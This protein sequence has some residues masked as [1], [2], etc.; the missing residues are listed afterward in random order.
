MSEFDKSKFYVVFDA[1]YVKDGVKPGMIPVGYGACHDLILCTLM[2]FEGDTNV[3]WTTINGETGGE[4]T[5]D[6]LFLLWEA[7]AESLLEKFEDGDTRKILCRY[8]YEVS[9]FGHLAPM[10]R[11]PDEDPQVVV[12]RLFLEFKE[13]TGKEPPVM[14]IPDDYRDFDIWAKW[15]VDYSVERMKA[16][17]DLATEDT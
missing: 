3:Q 10:L 6:K 15:V 16:L 1:K 2:H 5:P 11:L 12:P 14:Q 8:I 4:V 13:D 7:M 17:D 9:R